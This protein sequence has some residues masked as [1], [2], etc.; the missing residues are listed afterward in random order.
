MTRKSKTPVY[1]K[2]DVLTDYEF[3]RLRTEVNFGSREPVEEMIVGF[4]GERLVPMNVRFVPALATYFREVLDN[5]LDEIIGHNR[6]STIKVTYDPKKMVFSV[7][8]DGGGIPADLVD[9]LLAQ[10]RAGRNFRERGQVSGT[11]G[12]GAAAVN[13]CSRYFKIRTIHG[14]KSF[15]RE[16]REDPLSNYQD[17]AKTPAIIKTVW[18]KKSGTYIEFAP[19]PEVFPQMDLPETFVK[20]RVYELA[21]VYPGVKF[22]YN[23]SRIKVGRNIQQTLFKGMDVIPITVKG[24]TEVKHDHRSLDRDGSVKTYPFETTFYIVPDFWAGKELSHSVVNWV[25]A[26]NGGPHMQEFR[27]AFYNGVISALSTRTKQPSRADVSTNLLIFNVT[28]MA[29]PNFDSQSKTKLT[30]PEAGKIVKTSLDDAFF[31]QVMKKNQKWAKSIM[32]RYDERTGSSDHE[33]AKKLSKKASKSKVAKLSDATGQDRSKCTLIITEGDSA[34]RGIM[35]VR[36]TKTI[37][38]LPLRGKVMNVRGQ[39]KAKAAASEPLA[40]MM[41]ALGLQ[42]GK[43]AVRST[44]R[45][46][47]LYIATDEDEDG[48]NILAL[49]VNFLYMFW[50]ELFDPKNPFV[51]KLETP[52]IMCKKGK[53]SRYFYSRNVREFKPE[54]WKG[55]DIA[56]AKGLGRLTSSNWK[57]VLSNP[58]IIPIIDDGSMSDALDLIFNPDRT[59]DRKEWLEE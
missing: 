36:D 54:E 48:K 14:G 1:D 25:C 45:Y 27:T 23:G 47:K 56:R 5:A 57:D 16:Y 51:F 2:T 49:V 18:S 3:A 55:W 8:D 38:G 59:N 31:K 46:G 21:A 13:F 32:A 11:N 33:E 22:Y 35:Q 17:L 50:P 4:N 40:D 53:Q 10:A 7:E 15:T 42:I 24:Q 28:R 44:L 12:I 58:S 43:R 39:T 26:Y 20:A 41:G 6:G 9:Q 34:V 19:S 52:F 30:N 37:G 29:A